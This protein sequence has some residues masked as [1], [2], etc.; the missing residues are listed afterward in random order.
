MNKINKEILSTNTEIL[1]FFHHLSSY[2]L[3]GSILKTT[4]EENWLII[5]PSMAR[6][7]KLYT[8]III[9]TPTISPTSLNTSD[10]YLLPHDKNNY[11]PQHIRQK[12]LPKPLT[13]PSLESSPPSCQTK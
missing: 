13:K 8:K 2:K 12:F 1:S 5:T 6:A 7:D 4:L 11:T 3:Y 10:F 9:L